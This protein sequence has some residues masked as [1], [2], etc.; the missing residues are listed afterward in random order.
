MKK[1]LFITQNCTINRD[2]KSLKIEFEDNIA[3]VPLGIIENLFLVGGGIKLS[4]GARG[5]L[6]ENNK[7]ISFYT[8]HYKLQGILSNTKLQSNYRNR[9]FQY[10]AYKTKQLEISKYIVS[11]KIKSMQKIF[12]LKLNNHLSKSYDAE[13][14]NQLLGIEGISTTYMF[15]KFKKSLVAHKID[16]FKKREYRPTKDKVNG[17]LSFTYTLYSN[18]LYGLVLS[19]GYD[20]YIGFLHSKRGTHYAFVSDLIEFDRAKLTLFV[21]RLFIHKSL[22]D[23]DFEGIYLTY[24]GRKKY[25]QKFNQFVEDNFDTSKT[26]LNIIGDQLI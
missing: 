3:Q 20:P 2:A 11:R 18:L 8:S 26:N 12:D 23:D 15:K 7:M 14:L 9:L 10:D 19:E 4:N 13:D 6:L 24:E 1:N 5:L 22:I 16:D 25:L 17:V 21:L